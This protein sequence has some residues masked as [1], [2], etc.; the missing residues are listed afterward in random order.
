MLSGTR[1]HDFLLCIDSDGTIM[2]TMTVKHL[3][4]FGPCLFDAF[5]L[6]PHRE[7][8]LSEW[9]R[10]N[11]YSL[12]RGI[13]RFQGLKAILLF[14]KEHYGYAPDGLE[15]FEDFVDHSSALS[16]D[17]LKEWMAKSSH[18]VCLEMALKWSNLVNASIAS[19]PPAQEFK[20]VKETLKTLSLFADLLG[21]SSAN[22]GAV[23]EEWTSRGLMPYFLDCAC[24]DKG[25]K[26][27]IIAQGL[28]LGYSPDHIVMLG[29]ALGDLKA[30]EANH[31][32]FYPIIPTK[33]VESWERLQKEVAPLIEKGQYHDEVEARYIHEFH[34]FLENGGK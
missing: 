22:K 25:S 6:P 31:V 4:S 8:I 13:N 29:D 32:H 28:A 20:G 2:D 27:D 3:R 34:D 1:S 18:P 19:L 17:A 9:N 14:V 15:D 33:E 5:P 10:L 21:V 26:K 16:N 23:Y 30:A 12:T 11:L 24:Q 7:E